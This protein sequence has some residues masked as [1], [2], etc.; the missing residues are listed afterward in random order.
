VFIA[1]WHP[2]DGRTNM[3]CKKI[4]QWDKQAI[5]LKRILRY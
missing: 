4:R 3:A 2:S 1:V 5:V